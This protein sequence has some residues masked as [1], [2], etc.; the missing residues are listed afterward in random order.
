MLTKKEITTR[1]ANSAGITAAQAQAVLDEL[2]IVS[3]LELKKNDGKFR[4]P[5]F[6][7]MQRV[8][9]PAR[10]AHKMVNPFTKLPIK[11]A[12]KP[13]TKKVKIRPLIG[14]KNMVV[15]KRR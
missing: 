6:M 2:L 10:P 11:V 15:G 12:R 9:V 8:D 14:L 13:A 7:V 5:G 1:L 4:L 3:A